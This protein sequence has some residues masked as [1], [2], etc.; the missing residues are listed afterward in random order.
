MAEAAGDGSATAVNLDYQLEPGDVLSVS[1]WKEE[2]L[3]DVK[4]SPQAL[5]QSIT[6]LLCGL[7]EL[8]EFLV[9]QIFACYLWLFHNHPI[10]VLGS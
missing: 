3:Q 7:A 10:T 9:V 5:S 8:Q 6:N 2:G 1:V 4:V